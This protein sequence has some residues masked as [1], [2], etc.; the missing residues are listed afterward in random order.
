MDR[1]RGSSDDQLPATATVTRRVWLKVVL[2]AWV[3]DS[4]PVRRASVWC[5]AISRTTPLM[6]FAGG[7]QLMPSVEVLMWIADGAR[8]IGEATEAELPDQLIRG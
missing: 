2:D 4:I 1:R 7:I 5:I 8:I 6:Y 3:L